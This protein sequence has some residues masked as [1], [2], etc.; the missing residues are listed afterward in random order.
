MALLGASA[1]APEGEDTVVSSLW[2]PGEAFMQSTVSLCW[3]SLG[4]KSQMPPPHAASDSTAAV[5]HSNTGTQ[6]EHSALPRSCPCALFQSWNSSHDTNLLGTLSGERNLPSWD[7]LVQRCCR[8]PKL[9]Q[10][11]ST[12]NVCVKFKK[13]NR[14]CPERKNWRKKFLCWSQLCDLSAKGK[15]LW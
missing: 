15:A 14:L 10:G 4:S 12:W 9:Y 5:H 3:A 8:H 6:A 1:G 13:I 7:L 11:F 2:S